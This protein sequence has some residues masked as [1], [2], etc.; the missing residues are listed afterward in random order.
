LFVETAGTLGV[1]SFYAIYFGMAQQF[2]KVWHNN[3]QPSVPKPI[4]ALAFATYVCWALWAFSLT[5]TDT[6]RVVAML[7][8]III[9]PVVWL[10]FS[11]PRPTPNQILAA[12]AA[13]IAI[14]ALVLGLGL[15]FPALVRANTFLFTNLG[16]LCSLAYSAYA[17]PWQIRQLRTLGTAGSS[18]FFQFV[19]LISYV[20]WGIYAYLIADWTL[21]GL[22]C[23]GTL[24][25]AYVVWLSRPR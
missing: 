18:L 2:R 20:I 3:T 6:Y 23:L 13:G 25:Q 16:L 5:P 19:I 17:L 11:Q 24:L 15:Q 12:F 21:L 8:G 10:Q 7:P 4:F 9:V 14:L 1:L 22:Q